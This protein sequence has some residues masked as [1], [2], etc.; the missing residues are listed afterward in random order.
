MADTSKAGWKIVEEY[1]TDEV[2]S[3]PEDD[4]KMRKA[5]KR[6]ME[7]IAEE[8]EKKKATKDNHTK[9]PERFR[10]A[11]QREKRSKANDTCRNC[12]SPDC[13]RKWG[14]KASHFRPEVR[15]RAPMNGARKI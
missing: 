1:L 11:S 4:K 2:A 12:E 10:N 3:N 8:K 9:A 15:K 7:K 14:E 5:E 13:V 6:A